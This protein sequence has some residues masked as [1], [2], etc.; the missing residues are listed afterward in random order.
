MP[1]RG[2]PTGSQ[3]PRSQ[4]ITVPAP[5]CFGGIVP[6]KPPYDSGWSSTWIAMRFSFGSKLGPFGTAQLSSTPSSS[7]RKS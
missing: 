1:S 2:S 3:V 4:T 7:S 5:Y 6:S